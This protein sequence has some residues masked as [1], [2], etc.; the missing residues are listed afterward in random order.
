MNSLR[1]H[2][3]INYL[4]IA[5]TEPRR[6][7]AFY[8]ALFGWQVEARAPDDLRF[9]GADGRLIG[10]FVVGRSA[11]S[12]PGLL[13]YLYV[14]SVDGAVAQAQATGGELV[15]A[16]YPEGDVRVATVRDPAGNLLG[17][18]QFAA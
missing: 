18:W 2:G 4:E 9:S 3:A 13:P 5:A 6:S 8:Q 1:S 7:A 10:R 17:L 15:K 14:N 12:D 16:P 11:A